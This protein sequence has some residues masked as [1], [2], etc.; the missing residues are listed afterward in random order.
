MFIL[1]VLQM[2]YAKTFANKKA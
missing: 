2:F 1:H